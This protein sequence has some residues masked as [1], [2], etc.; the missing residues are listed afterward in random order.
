MQRPGVLDTCRRSL[1]KGRSLVFLET[2]PFGHA[3]FFVCKVFLTV[4]SPADPEQTGQV[5]EAVAF[6]VP[7]WMGQ[8][9]R[10]WFWEA[11]WRR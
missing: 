10:G 7:A 11:D 1:S 3:R 6:G 8:G 9:A 4:T 5:P 2:G